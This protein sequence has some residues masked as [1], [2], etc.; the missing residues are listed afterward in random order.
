MAIQHLAQN[1]IHQVMTTMRSEDIRA[2]SDL[3]KRKV[4]SLSPKEFTVNEA[5]GV[6][7]LIG[8]LDVLV[9]HN[10]LF[11]FH[12]FSSLVVGSSNTPDIF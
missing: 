9:G 10:K 8:V 1:V 11:F 6:F 12:G 5:L 7:V 2:G 4:Q 3:R